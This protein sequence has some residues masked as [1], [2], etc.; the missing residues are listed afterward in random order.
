MMRLLPA[1]REASLHLAAHASVAVFAIV[2]VCVLF[3][4]LHIYVFGAGYLVNRPP[5]TSLYNIVL[6]WATYAALVPFVLLLTKKYRL[7][8]Q[9]WH[10]K[11]LIHTCVA[12]SF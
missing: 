12:I 11:L 9:G 2:G 1:R 3:D 4:L 5:R 6:F 8:L 10:R 7:D